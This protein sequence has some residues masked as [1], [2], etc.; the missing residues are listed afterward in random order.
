[1]RVVTHLAVVV[2]SGLLILVQ[3]QLSEFDGL[4]VL[5]GCHAIAA[6]LSSGYKFLCGFGGYGG[7]GGSYLLDELCGRRCIIFNVSER[8]VTAIRILARYGV[9][10]LG[11]LQVNHGL[12]GHRIQIAVAVA[13]SADISSR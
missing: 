6:A 3:L 8:G 2:L 1:M 9:P 4:L 13:I 5:F 11:Y 12:H 10:L 7:G